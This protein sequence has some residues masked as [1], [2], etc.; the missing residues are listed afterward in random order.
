MFLPTSLH[1][2]LYLATCYLLDDSVPYAV[3]GTGDTTGEYSVYVLVP[4]AREGSK[5]NPQ[6]GLAFR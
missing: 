1:T 5:V 3:P 4:I 2:P 6:L